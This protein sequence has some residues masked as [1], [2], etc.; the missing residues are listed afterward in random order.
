MADVV[1]RRWRTL[2]RSTSPARIEH[3]QAA[4]E[5]AMYGLEAAL[6]WLAARR[7]VFGRVPVQA[8]A[9]YGA[10]EGAQRAACRLAFPMDRPPPKLNPGENLC[11]RASGMPASWASLMAASLVVMQ[12]AGSRRA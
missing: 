8:V 2:R 5:S 6:L 3:S 9:A 12:I 11:D 4:W 10:M 1:G 7:I